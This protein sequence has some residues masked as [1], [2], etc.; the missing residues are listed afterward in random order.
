MATMREIQNGIKKPLGTGVCAQVWQLCDNE[1]KA[2]GVVPT[3]KA[4]ADKYVFL[5]RNNVQIE[6]SAWRKFYGHI[7][8]RHASN[9]VTMPVKP[10]APIV[11]GEVLADIGE[12]DA[13][14]A[15]L[16][17]MLAKAQADALATKQVQ[18]LREAFGDVA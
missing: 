1:F 3:P 8:G 18:A 14:V 9:V 15:E 12:A 4:M 13:R 5:N 16:Q 10:V 6:T 2:T 7:A 17:A 11:H